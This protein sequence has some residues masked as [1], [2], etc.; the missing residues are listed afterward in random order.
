MFSGGKVVKYVL[1]SIDWEKKC[2][3]KLFFLSGPALTPSPT[4][5]GFFCGI[6]RSVRK[7]GTFSC[8]NF[9]FYAPFRVMSLLRKTVSRVLKAKNVEITR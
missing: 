5:R 7:Y 3:K 8:E 6:P 2:L 9:A 1:L 4:N